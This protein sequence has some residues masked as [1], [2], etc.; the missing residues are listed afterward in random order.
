MPGP[1]PSTRPF[2]FT[3]VLAFLAAA[4]SFDAAAEDRVQ[5]YRDALT[6]DAD[7]VCEKYMLPALAEAWR[8]CQT[9]EPVFVQRPA[10]LP[11]AA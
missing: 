4:A 11:L 5:V 9:R 6:Y 8:R 1:G 7:L 2:R 3:R 10:P